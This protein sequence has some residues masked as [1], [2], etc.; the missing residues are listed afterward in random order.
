MSDPEEQPAA[1]E[2]SEETDFTAREFPG[3]KPYEELSDVEIKKYTDRY[4][5][6]NKESTVNSKLGRLQTIARITY[7]KTEKQ[8]L[9]EEAGQKAQLE[10]EHVFTVLEY[11]AVHVCTSASSLVNYCSNFFELLADDKLWPPNTRMEATMRRR[12]QNILDRRHSAAAHP[13][14]LQDIN[15]VNKKSRWQALIW[16]F[17]GLRHHHA[18]LLRNRDL[19]AEE[20]GAVL[21]LRILNDKNTNSSERTISI[22]CACFIEEG[23]GKND[24]LCLIHEKVNQK[25]INRV[26]KDRSSRQAP[27]LGDI[28]QILASTLWDKH[29]PHVGLM[30]AIQQFAGIARKSTD[31]TMRLQRNRICAYMGWASNSTMPEYYTRSQKYYDANTTR[32]PIKAVV[33]NLLAGNTDLQVVKGDGTE[34]RLI[35]IEYVNRESVNSDIVEVV[36]GIEAAVKGASPGDLV[37]ITVEEATELAKL[38][39]RGL[40]RKREDEEKV[41]G[42][43]NAEKAK[44]PKQ[45]EHKRRKTEQKQD[46]K[47]QNPPDGGRPSKRAKLVA[48]GT[49]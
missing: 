30:Q 42:K 45:T 46:K 22:R 3:L 21:Q 11:I 20:D 2:E 13:P 48:P 17:S 40:K 19:T 16:L 34:A 8:I 7:Y 43:S 12:A 35:D 24:E 14:D 29:S 31:K 36:K 38:A 4:S 26:L 32:V 18:S 41:V 6:F 27:L 39:R 28:K 25:N 15:L 9:R 1:P 23:G 44:K 33:R 10:D 37:S 49:K 5:R 47:K